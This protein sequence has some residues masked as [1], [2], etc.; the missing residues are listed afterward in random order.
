MTMNWQIF[1]YA[2]EHFSKLKKIYQNEFNLEL[3]RRNHNQ[4]EVFYISSEATDE[5]ILQI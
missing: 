4:M 3:I 2:S 1:F 5:Q